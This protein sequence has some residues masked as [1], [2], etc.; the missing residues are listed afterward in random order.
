MFG[1]SPSEGVVFHCADACVTVVV[2]D[3]DG[4]PSTIPFALDPQTPNQQLRYLVRPR[5]GRSPPFPPP[6][7]LCVR[8]CVCVCVCVC[9]LLSRSS[10]AT[11]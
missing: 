5:T 1:E 4:G 7:S 11:W 6:L 8:V 9:V 3:G 2:V 10:C